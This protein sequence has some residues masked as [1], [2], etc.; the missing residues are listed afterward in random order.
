[1]VVLWKVVCATRLALDPESLVKLIELFFIHHIYVWCRAFVFIF[2]GIGIFEEATYTVAIMFAGFVCGP[3]TIGPAGNLLVMAVVSIYCFCLLPYK[4]DPESSKIERRLNMFLNARWRHHISKLQKRLGVQ[5]INQMATA[6]SVIERRETVKV[7]VPQEINISKDCPRAEEFQEFVEKIKA[8]ESTMTE[9]EA[10]DKAEAE[11]DGPMVKIGSKVTKVNIKVGDIVQPG[12]VAFEVKDRAPEQGYPDKKTIFKALDQD[13]NGYL[14]RDE[15]ANVLVSWGVGP[16]EALEIFDQL[17]GLKESKEDTVGKVTEEEF[18]EEWE[19]IW[20]YQVDAIENAINKYRNF[21]SNDI[22]RGE[23]NKGSAKL[24]TAAHTLAHASSSMSISVGE[25]SM[26]NLAL[27]E[28]VEERAKAKKQG[29]PEAGKKGKKQRVDDVISGAEKMIGFDQ[30]NTTRKEDEALW[31]YTIGHSQEAY[32]PDNEEALRPHDIMDIMY[33]HLGCHC[34]PCFAH[35]REF[36]AAKDG[37]PGRVS[38]PGWLGMVDLALLVLAIPFCLV[39]MFNQGGDY[40]ELC[41]L[42]GVLTLP[43]YFNDM[44]CYQAGVIALVAQQVE[45]K[46]IFLYNTLFCMSLTYIFGADDMRWV[47]IWTALFWGINLVAFADAC[48]FQAMTT[49]RTLEI[50]LITIAVPFLLLLWLGLRST[51]GDPY[52]QWFPRLCVDGTCDAPGQGVLE[53]D[54]LIDGSASGVQPDDMSWLTTALT[55][56]QTNLILLCKSVFNHFQN[57]RTA[58]ILQMKVSRRDVHSE[59]QLGSLTKHE[60][61]LILKYRQMKRETSKKDELEVRTQR[62]ME[63]EESAEEDEEDQ[64]W[65]QGSD[66]EDDGDAPESAA[67]AKPAKKKQTRKAGADA[68]LAAQR[69]GG[70]K[71]KKE[72]QNPMSDILND[73]IEEDMSDSDPEDDEPIAVT[74]QPE[75]E[76]AA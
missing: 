10:L 22:D 1:M 15:V 23:Y 68:V 72:F 11:Y 69:K 6:E 65:R 66:E 19:P 55:M 71:G 64:D 49:K 58:M 62:L 13:R 14:D 4:H 61:D 44:L 36:L 38:Y 21:Q 34:I 39:G 18:Y 35:E 75:P 63:E 30:S 53:T 52:F 50:A 43:H 9:E 26:R 48:T 5:Q 45:A 29:K 41:C 51:R 40:Q 37:A 74:A 70:K 67:E 56:L 73:G 31:D 2:E 8:D 32:R 54:E 27:Q 42:A 25:K 28:E 60:R 33:S 7:Q 46:L 17:D 16:G 76:P 12:E 20:Q 59:V 57:P 3:M 47:I 24:K